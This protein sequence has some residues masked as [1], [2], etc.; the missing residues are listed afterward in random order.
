MGWMS[1][2]SLVA[3]FFGGIAFLLMRPAPT[4]SQDQKAVIQEVANALNENP[5][6]LNATKENQ[7]PAAVK[8]KGASRAPAS[9]EVAFDFQQDLKKEVSGI[10][11]DALLREYQDHPERTIELLREGIQSASA[12]HDFNEVSQVLEH[13]VSLAEVTGAE[14]VMKILDEQIEIRSKDFRT[15]S[16]IEIAHVFYWRKKLQEIRS[17]Q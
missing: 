5:R 8:E 2:V 6:L 9:V 13:V 11:R 15:E 12:G 14:P 4:L 17:R 7:N 1:A 3:V 10:S 16:Q